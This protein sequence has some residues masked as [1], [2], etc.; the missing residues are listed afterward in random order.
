L[1]GYELEAATRHARARWESPE[2]AAALAAA[3]EDLRAR[4]PWTEHLRELPDLDHM[5]DGGDLA[6]AP[7]AG[8]DLRDGMAPRIKFDHADLREADLTGAFLRGSQFIN[9]DLREARLAYADLMDA[10]LP[11]ADLTGADLTGANLEAAVLTGANL[12]DAVFAGADLRGAVLFRADTTGADF[13]GAD[14]TDARLT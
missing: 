13:E 10:F 8:V 3:L 4:R 12:R 1:T 11:R 5:A 6:G 7:L 2:I 14:L 9:A